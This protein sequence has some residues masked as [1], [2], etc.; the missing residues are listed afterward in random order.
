MNGRY[1]LTQLLTQ[2][3]VSKHDFYKM[4]E[5]HKNEKMLIYQRFNVFSI[6]DKMVH[7]RHNEPYHK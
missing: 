4:Y 5:K 2:K 3:S 7:I 6:H 1:S